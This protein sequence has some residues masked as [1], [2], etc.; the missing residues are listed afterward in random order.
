MQMT[1]LPVQVH[2]RREV[3]GLQSP[4]ETDKKR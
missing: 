1:V 4:Q 2:W 3:Y